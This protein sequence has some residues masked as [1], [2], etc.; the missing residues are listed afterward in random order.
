[1]DLGGIAKGWAVDR[2]IEAI[3]AH[4][5]K[6]AIVNAGGDLYAMGHSERGDAWEI[7]IQDPRNPGR[8]SRTLEL[9][10][11]AVATSGDYIQY[12]EYQ[13]RRYH[14]IMDPITASPRVTA[15]HSVTVQA[16]T[17]MAAD[18]ACGSVYGLAAP[19]AARVL[20]RL[21]GSARVLDV[22]S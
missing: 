14:H 11:A 20:A 7:G 15:V 10:D 3:R 18:V 16:A 4:G 9:S 5:F 12:F 19:Q 17:C 8:I 6:D 2:A 21:D 22:E 1:V 13:G